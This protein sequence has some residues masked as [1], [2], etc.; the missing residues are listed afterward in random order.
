MKE[1]C[2]QLGSANRVYIDFGDFSIEI[3]ME[4]KK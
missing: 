4:V 2:S 1:I 3:N